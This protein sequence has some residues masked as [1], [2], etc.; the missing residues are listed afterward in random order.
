MHLKRPWLQ[1]GIALGFADG[2]YKEIN[3]ETVNIPG[4]GRRTFPDTAITKLQTFTV[5]GTV[6]HTFYLSGLK[7]KGNLIFTPTVMVNAGES[8]FEVTHRNVYS[9][10]IQR[11]RRNILRNQ[12]EIT[13]FTLQSLGLNFQF[14]YAIGKFNFQPQLYLDYYLPETEEKRL[15]EL[16][17]FN[18]GFTF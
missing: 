13:S 8:K 7:E 15:N 1:P 16:Y 5:V 11:R 6:E 9:A 2:E 18:I 12:T 10:A 17:N 4:R 14:N 3:I